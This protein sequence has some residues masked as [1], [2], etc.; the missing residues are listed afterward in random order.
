MISDKGYMQVYYEIAFEADPASIAGLTYSG[1]DVISVANNHAFDYSRTAFED[2]LARLSA[3]GIDYIGGGDFEE[4]YD[5]K[6]FDVKGTR[7]AF[8]AFTM[9]GNVS[10]SIMA[11]REDY[12]A[13][14]GVAWYYTEYADPA[15]QKAKS[16]ADLVIVSIHF[17]TEYEAAQNAEQ[18]EAAKHLI[19]RG[20]DLII[21]H[22]P[23]VVQPLTSYGGGFIA[24]SLGNFIFDQSNEATHRGMVLEVTV[25]DKRIESVLD[26]YININN[27]YQPVME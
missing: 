25:R 2:C 20:A 24:Y 17:G 11:V 27:Y 22:H 9:T 21:G 26:K 13:R 6:V 10:E 18:E 3:A 23:H 15:V 19:D 12:P 5:P 4:A 14:A 8:L 7:I 1:I 16:M